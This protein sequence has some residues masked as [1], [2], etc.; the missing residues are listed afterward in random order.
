MKARFT[1]EAEKD[2]DE[3]IAW[4]DERGEGLG[5]EVLRRI[6]ESVELI[7]R[8]PEMYPIVHR[9]MRRAI[10][11]QFPYQVIYEVEP[12]EIVIYAVY[13]S[14]RDPKEWKRR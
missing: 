7:E 11:R 1:P 9:R 3:A 13:H 12:G 14:A 10:V 2:L 6:D 8:Y 4:Y 5:D